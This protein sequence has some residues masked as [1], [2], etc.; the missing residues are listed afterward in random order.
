MDCSVRIEVP[1]EAKLPDGIR[2]ILRLAVIDRLNKAAQDPR[3]LFYGICLG[4]GEWRVIGGMFVERYGECISTTFE[5]EFRS[6]E[7]KEP[8]VLKVSAE[9]RGMLVSSANGQR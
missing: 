7:L 5:A 9:R 6:D 2:D 4:V 1:A 8:V 3:A